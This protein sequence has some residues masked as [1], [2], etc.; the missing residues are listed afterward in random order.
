MKLSEALISALK[1][2][3]RV[4]VLA[5]IPLLIDSLSA[6]EINWRI[7][8]IAGVIALLRFLDKFL[9]EQEPEGVAGGLT[10]F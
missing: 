2:G 3:A 6:G 8:A 4:V 7:I 9:H 10:R 1:E 5:V